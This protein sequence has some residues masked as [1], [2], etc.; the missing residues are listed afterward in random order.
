M[1][2]AGHSPGAE[3]RPAMSRRRRSLAIPDAHG[4]PGVACPC[5]ATYRPG[6]RGQEEAHR[7]LAN[8]GRL[9]RRRHRRPTSVLT[10]GN[11]WD[12]CFPSGLR[13]VRHLRSERSQTAEGLSIRR[14]AGGGRGRPS[15][16]RVANQS[17]RSTCSRSGRACRPQMDVPNSAGTNTV[18]G[19]VGR[20]PDSGMSGRVAA[21]VSGQLT[22]RGGVAQQVS[23]GHQP[24][25]WGDGERLGLGREKGGDLSA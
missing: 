6:S 10:L 16:P 21:L 3:H 1:A 2:P 24:A 7:N 17:A 15:P 11:A 22:S 14:A 25:S 20:S 19:M 4:R 12:R 18:C 13:D 5:G 9:R 8:G 23:Q